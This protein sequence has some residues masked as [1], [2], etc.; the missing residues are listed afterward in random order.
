MKRLAAL[1]VAFTASCAAFF[2]LNGKANAAVVTANQTDDNQNTISCEY[3]ADG[4]R[5]NDSLMI[6][7]TEKSDGTAT[8]NR[9]F[10]RA[11]NVTIPDTIRVSSPSGTQEYRPTLFNCIYP[12]NGQELQSVTVPDSINMIMNNAFGYSTNGTKYNRNSSEVP[13]LVKGSK[14]S[15]F[16]V[17]CNKNTAA[18]SY[19][20]RNGFAAELPSSVS[21]STG[22]TTTSGTTTTT[23]SGEADLQINTIMGANLISWDSINNCS[24]IYL[25]RVNENTKASTLVTVLNGSETSYLDNAAESNCSYYITANVTEN[26]SSKVLT[27]D[28][29][30]TV[31]DFGDLGAKMTIGNGTITISWNKVNASGYVVTMDDNQVYDTL[32][33]DIT[34]YT[35]TGLKN[36]E[37][38][39]FTVKP[40]VKTTS[41]RI[42]YGTES[43]KLSTIGVDSILNS[44][45]T[46]ETRSF[47][48]HNK[49]GAATKT[50]TVEITD[51]D[52]AILEKFAKEN[53]TEDMTDAQKLETTLNWINLNLKYAS[54]SSDWNKINGK[55]YADSVFTYKIGQC[56]QYNGAMVSM[57][58]Y[59]GY[60]ADLILGWRGT[61]NTNYWQHL[62]G[63]VDI[64]GMKYLIETG[65]NG[66]SGSWSFL[67][68]PYERADGR[69]ITNCKNIELESFNDYYSWDDWGDWSGWYW[70]Y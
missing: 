69:Y 45:K 57:M 42:N 61:W 28:S 66:K 2:A 36:Y 64:N 49:Q 59:L 47:K 31:V 35:K 14:I 24:M 55:T 8:I 40:Y 21:G 13:Q 5:L 16:K 20:L 33:G 51:K 9:I 44:A 15:D 12:E 11:V 3:D 58:R 63:E 18:E 1:I 37:K 10:T 68:V 56:A 53:F 50:S 38:H 39:V 22:S 4:D 70:W 7:T 48:L 65:N 43:E 30:P 41:G 27:L 6:F 19:A 67:L 32:S 26:G 60:D 29:K 34:S 62:W 54:T 52:I 46:T 17:I 23:G 25:Y